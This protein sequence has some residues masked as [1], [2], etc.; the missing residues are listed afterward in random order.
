MVGP[1]DSVSGDPEWGEWQHLSHHQS[2]RQACSDVQRS[3]AHNQGFHVDLS[4]ACVHA[5]GVGVLVPA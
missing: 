2:H 4:F 3:D 5:L 1:C